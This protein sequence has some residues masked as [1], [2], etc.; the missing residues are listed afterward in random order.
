MNKL[1]AICKKDVL[2]SL[3]T[4]LAYILCSA[5]IFMSGFFF[6]S[7]LRAFG[8]SQKIAA[9]TG[10]V[11][12]SFNSAVIIPLYQAQIVLLL[13][14]VPL[15]S[16]RSFSEEKQS[17]S[18]ELLLTM[19]VSLTTLVVAKWLALLALIGGVLILGGVYPLLIC[20]IGDPEV[21][22]V[23]VGGF[24]LFL[25][26]GLISALGVFVSSLCSSQ[27]V[28]GIL[29]LIFGL[30]WFL[31]DIPFGSQGTDFAIFIKS[32]AVSMAVE[33]LFHGVLSVSN[34][35]FFIGGIIAFLFLTVQTLSSQS[36]R[37]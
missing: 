5:Y 9:M 14:I 25:F 35:Y 32:L 15:I 22:P 8:P 29:T 10:G 12:L 30:A 31:I 3:T 24:G 18:L 6:F 21:L 11:S 19:P 34:V 27:S 26:L 20:V 36:G 23:L 33:E 37:V 17:G 28:A 7:Y 4:P 13:F 1:L 16:M 2:V